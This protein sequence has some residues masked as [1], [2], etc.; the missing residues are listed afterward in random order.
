MK[1]HLL[2]ILVI[3]ALQLLGPQQAQA[4]TVDVS[5]TGVPSCISAFAVAAPPGSRLTVCQ[6]ELVGDS[7]NDDPSTI[8]VVDLLILRHSFGYMFDCDIGGVAGECLG[9]GQSLYQRQVTRRLLSENEKQELQDKAKSW[10]W[11]SGLSG[12][13]FLV[14][15]LGFIAGG[16]AGIS[17]GISTI[18]DIRAND[19]PRFDYEQIENYSGAG[20]R[21]SNGLGA[22]FDAFMFGLSQALVRVE[23]TVRGLLLSQER[24]QGAVI[25]GDDAAIDAQAA[26]QS[27]FAAN[28]LQALHDAGVWLESLPSA[29]GIIGIEDIDINDSSIMIDPSLLAAYPDVNTLFALIISL[30]RDFQTAGLASPIIPTV[31]AETSEVPIPGAWFLML[32]GLVTLIPTRAGRDSLRIHI[33]DER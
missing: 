7:R 13:F 25:D 22:S 9:G 4:T 3:V 11:V 16:V 27:M 26:A 24:L 28:E 18:Y 29:L 32:V 10:Q 6:T 21:S 33:A 31:V 14:P 2:A 15:G 30:G 12:P 8:G 23:E 17:V 20:V 5:V 19:P 1:K